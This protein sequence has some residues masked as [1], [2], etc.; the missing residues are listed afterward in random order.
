MKEE[1]KR[2][3]NQ[4]VEQIL[5]RWNVVSAQAEYALDQRA[6]ERA[7]QLTTNIGH[8]VECLPTEE[9]ECIKSLYFHRLSWV[10]TTARMCISTHT[11]SRNRR[12]AIEDITQALNGTLLPGENCNRD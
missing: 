12:R 11:L 8:I 10:C 3:T 4:Q 5:K 2:I 9:R 1:R 6:K 7:K